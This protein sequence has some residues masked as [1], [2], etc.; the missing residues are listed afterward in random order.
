MIE[1]NKLVEVL[2]DN[3]KLSIEIGGH[4]DNTGN[5]ADNIKL[6]GNRAKSVVDYL[7]SKGIAAARLTWKG[8]GATKPIA[9]NSKE[10]GKAKNRRT[11]FKV[12]AL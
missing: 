7:V 11:E 9:D 8:Y 1:L 3:P 6:S 2:N 12:T 4:T 5:A 10:E